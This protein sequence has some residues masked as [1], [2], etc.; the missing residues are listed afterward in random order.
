M[1]RGGD[2]NIIGIPELPLLLPLADSQRDGPAASRRAGR[3]LLIFAIA[4]PILLA[5]ILLTMVLLFQGDLVAQQLLV[6]YNAAAPKIGFFGDSTIRAISAC[7]RDTNGID[8]M[9]AV[10]TGWTVTTL[11]GAGY[12]P[13]QWSSL[14]SL[15]ATTRHKPR[16]VVFPINLRSYSTGWG[17]NPAWQ[18]GPQRQYVRILSGELTAIPQF[19][20]DSVLTS[21]D[22][23]TEVMMNT[24]ISAMGHHYG[25]LATLAGRAEGV[26][27]DLECRGDPAPYHD[28]LKAKFT[29]NYMFDLAADHPL[30]GSL[31]AFVDELASHDIA[32]AAYLVPINVAEGNARVGPDFAQA[33]RHNK[34][35]VTAALARARV[36][37]VDLTEALP[38]ENFADRGC[39]CE[40]LAASGRKAVAARIAEMLRRLPLGIESAVK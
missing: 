36:P 19:V 6:R 14:A 20:L 34:A 4:A 21:T 8:D 31:Q 33:I 9:L 10:A 12:T 25:S 24:E 17:A 23:D 38:A 18:F 32:M 37:Y 40:H 35:I 2:K 11:A 5:P 7:E 22:A 1:A 16:V 29:L 30:L 39:A 3:H 26:P 15:F 13:L 28:A 27:L